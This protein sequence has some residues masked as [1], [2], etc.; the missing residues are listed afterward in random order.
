MKMRKIIC[1]PCMLF[2]KGNAKSAGKVLMGTGAWL[3][4]GIW[5][6]PTVT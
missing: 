6:F 3:L 1:V 2:K 4:K 5:L